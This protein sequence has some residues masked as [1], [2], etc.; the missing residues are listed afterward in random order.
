MFNDVSAEAKLSSRS[1]VSTGQCVVMLAGAEVRLPEQAA[2]RRE[3]L[4]D[5][6]GRKGVGRLEVAR[7]LAGAAYREQAIDA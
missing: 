5:G 2:Y 3:K 4:P 6:S 1:V 7:A